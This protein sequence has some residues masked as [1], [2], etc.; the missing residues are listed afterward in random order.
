[1]ISMDTFG[2]EY[3]AIMD[4]ATR[5]ATDSAHTR[6][7]R[8]ER[9]GRADPDVIQGRLRTNEDDPL[10]GTFNR[11]REDNGSVYEQLARQSD[12]SNNA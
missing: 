11:A 1:M 7:L 9:A 3:V 8:A 5:R 4:D 6:E 10:V 12:E 2:D